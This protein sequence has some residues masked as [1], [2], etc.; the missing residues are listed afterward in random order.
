MN[1]RCLILGIVVLWMLAAFGCGREETPIERRVREYAKEA[2]DALTRG[3][4]HESRAH[5]MA[6]LQLAEQ[7]E[8]QAVVGEHSLALAMLFMQSARFDSAALL[9]ARAK[10]AYASQGDKEGA[11]A[12]VLAQARLYRMR[13]EDRQALQLLQE[14]AR[15]EEAVGEVYGA[16]RL[17]EA[18]LPL[19]ITLYDTSL[20]HRV[21]T[22][23]Q[24]AY[25]QENNVKGVALLRRTAGVSLLQRSEFDEALRAFGDALALAE[26][27]HDSLLV[28]E[29][30]QWRAVAY[31]KMG[32][33][34]DAFAAFTA[35]LKLTDLTRGSASLREEMLMRVG[36][37]YL[38]HNQRERA[39]TFFTTALK[40]AIARGNKLLEGYAV[41]QLAHCSR[42]TADA[43]AMYRAAAELLESTDVLWA[44]VYANACLGYVALSQKNIGEALSAFRSAAQDELLIPQREPFDVFVDCEQ[45]LSTLE[46]TTP[47]EILTELLLQLQSYD[48]AFLWAERQ[49][50]RELLHMYNAM[51]PRTGNARV[52][53]AVEIFAHLR[54]NTIGTLN[55]LAEAGT[56][57]DVFASFGPELRTRLAAARRR[58]AHAGDSLAE[59]FPRMSALFT[60]EPA[61][62][63]EIQ[64]A[65]PDG[66]ALVLL[67]PTRRALYHLVLTNRALVPSI[68][69][70][71]SADL[72]SMVNDYA[73]RIAAAT[74]VRDQQ[75]T[76]LQR[77]RELS[78]RLYSVLV[79]PAER[80]AQG[81]QRLIFLLPEDYPLIPL[82]ALQAEGQRGAY[83]VQRFAVQYATDTDMLRFER[84]PL[85]LYP[86]VVGFGNPGRSAVDVEY[87]VRDAKAFFREAK[88]LLGREAIWG[89]LQR[90]SGDFLH[91]ALELHLHADHPGAS[92]IVLKDVAG[93]AGTQAVPMGELFALPPFN[94]ILLS[95][96]QESGV[97]P[98]VVRILKMNG[99]ASV[100][101]NSAMPSRK[102]KK[103]FNEGFYA[104]LLRG[105]AVDVA[106]RN[107]L[108]EML[109]HPEHA[110]PWQ[111]GVFFL[112]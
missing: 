84:P 71:G 22:E 42:Q 36:N 32:K 51:T 80:A 65:L 19:C 102:V 83:V 11:R 52:N 59:A 15:L 112:W 2:E 91:A 68:G 57:Y 33:R 5:R 94:T 64:R 55:A 47:P 30:H 28:I 62:L 110:Q 96:V 49:R 38:R 43:P 58:M 107:A 29:L 35:G 79:R 101:T 81:T 86:R 4:L 56:A 40:S 75:G 61:S 34:A 60:F 109:K 48:E 105:A 92:A 7:L 108:L 98:A 104:H 24:E 74:H 21:Q 90:E 8:D 72:K 67:F 37:I 70:T 93:Y 103:L 50:R 111:W 100:V 87:E 31:E 88:L 6:A 9:I 99:T 27:E 46:Q 23:L 41:L 77:L 106:Y 54:H 69:A 76:S 89:A 63:K 26:S 18:M 82:H 66:A 25:G 53:E 44:R 1:G 85:K 39:R 95:S 16:R 13:G 73:R 78:S 14:Q 12:A 3:D 97:P 17:K 20:E 10:E 45:T